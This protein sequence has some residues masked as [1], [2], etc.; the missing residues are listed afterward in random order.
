MSIDST[1]E[2]L[3]HIGANTD[4]ATANI[5]RFRT[6]LGKDLDGITGEFGAWAS[7]IV[8]SVTTVQGAL[9][10][11]GALMGAGLVAVAGFALEAAHKYSEFVDQV[12]R[13]TKT[14]GM[15][16]EAMSQLKFAADL[17]GTSYD[18]LTGGLTKFAT[19][20]VKAA[21]GSEQQVKAF[22]ALGISHAQVVAGEKDLNGLLMIV[23]D[24]FHELGSRVLQTAEARELFGRGGAALVKMLSQGS[25]GLHEMGV[26]AQELGLVL[27][28]QDREANEAY[29]LSI[30][31]LKAELEGFVVT[32][33]REILP[34]LTGTLAHI[35]GYAQALKHS[36]S[37]PTSSLGWWASFAKIASEGE[38]N[39]AAFA[40][41]MEALAKS[42]A[43]YGTEN[44]GLA[45]VAKAA[46][47]EWQGLS[48]MLK[49]VREETL[50]LSSVDQKA[51]KDL[52]HTQFELDKLTAKYRE[53]S[54]AGKLTKEDA[55]TQ[56]AALAAMPAALSALM[57]HYIDQINK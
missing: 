3:F 40:A 54:A 5:A 12:A 9:T 35:V 31:A 24:R 19:T 50:Q 53:L 47:G 48:D 52:E 37:M 55:A 26:R 17:T 15:S 25:A 44:K 30:H 16:M 51:T 20:V 36:L 23:A 45:D 4:D 43:K 49:K 10:A 56:A 27:S 42:L 29:K 34:A 7:K 2:L 14:T 6:L 41:R 1:A 8:G 39:A 11:T 38:M 33:G 28:G 21:Q 46:K 22:A 18:A 32:L 57:T 13:G